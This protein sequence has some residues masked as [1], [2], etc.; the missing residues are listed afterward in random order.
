MKFKL[1]YQKIDKLRNYKYNKK[2][3]INH[4][5]NVQENLYNKKYLVIDQM[6]NLHKTKD[7]H[8][9]ITVIECLSL[10]KVVS[11]CTKRIDYI[12]HLLEILEKIL[13]QS[14]FSTKIS[15]TPVLL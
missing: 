15:K 11:E 3:Q 4:Y 8:A 2:K 10:L 9:T 7:A 13:P 5:I 6:D 14:L 12:E 1:N